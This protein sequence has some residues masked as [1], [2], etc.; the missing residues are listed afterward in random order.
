MG[1]RVGIEPEKMVSGS[2]ENVEDLEDD[3]GIEKRLEFFKISVVDAWEDSSDEVDDENDSKA[4]DKFSERYEMV[5]SNSWD[6]EVLIVTELSS[7]NQTSLSCFYSL[8]CVW[9]IPSWVAHVSW[10][11]AWT[12]GSQVG[13]LWQWEDAAGQRLSE[14]Y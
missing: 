8:W 2:F 11:T 5:E 9:L 4:V 7:W 13:D 12:A 3:M 6:S 14:E 1:E 10:Q